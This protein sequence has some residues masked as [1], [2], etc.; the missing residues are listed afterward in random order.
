MPKTF[1]VLWLCCS[2]C[3]GAAGMFFHDSLYVQRSQTGGATITVHSAVSGIKIYSDTVLLGATPLDSLQIGEGKHILTFV[4][5]EAIKWRYSSIVET[6]TVHPSEHLCRTV[7][8][9][10]IY[11]ITSTPFNAMVQ[12][13]DSVIGQTPLLLSGTLR[14]GQIIIS[15]EGYQA[16][17]LSLN[18]DNFEVHAELRPLEHTV[19]HTRSMYLADIQPK[20]NLPIY[21]TTGTSVI[22]GVIAAY[23]KIKADSYYN[24]YQI[25]RNPHTLN[26][27]KRL[28][29]LSG[30]SLA[31]SEVSLVML[32]YFL[33]SR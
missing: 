32:S 29:T 6:V 13:G 5:P 14:A 17:I 7:S 24:D 12:Y 11:H 30:I 28:D 9:P 19:P 2:C 31:V 26:D 20:N 10:I 21:I 8:F 16:A 25:N 15:K 27:V 4:N 33:I 23:C 22:S 1:I 18:T 3:S